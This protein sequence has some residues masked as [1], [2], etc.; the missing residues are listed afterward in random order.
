MRGGFHNGAGRAICDDGLIIDL[1]PMRAVSVDPETGQQDQR[2]HRQCLGPRILGGPP[3]AR[4]RRRGYVNVMAL[5]ED[6]VR[7]SYGE[8]KYE[9]LARIKAKY[10]PDNVF[11]RNVNIKPALQPI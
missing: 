9:R 4:Q 1:S 8:V 11:R 10:D 6:R 5:D 2:E 7:E 3:A